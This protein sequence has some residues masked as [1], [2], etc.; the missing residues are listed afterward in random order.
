MGSVAEIRTELPSDV[1]GE[2]ICVAT[3][4]EWDLRGFGF[5]QTSDLKRVYVHHSAFG[6]G[7]LT[8]GEQVKVVVVPDLRNP[9]KLMAKTLM[10]VPETTPKRAPTLPQTSFSQASVKTTEEWLPGRVTEWNDPR[11][12]GF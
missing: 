6:A 2:P 5:V 9:G 4:T 1:Q 12:F 8:V 3:V 7:D 11:G 10:K